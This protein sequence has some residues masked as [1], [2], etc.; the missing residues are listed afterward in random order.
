MER[1]PR[2]Q[3]TRARRYV[4]EEEQRQGYEEDVRPV[5]AVHGDQRV[6]ARV[7][8]QGR[9][10]EGQR[11]RGR[12]HGHIGHDTARLEAEHHPQRRDHPVAP[13]L[14]GPRHDDRFRGRA[15]H[16]PCMAARE[17]HQPRLQPF[18]QPHRRHQAGRRD[19][20]NGQQPEPK[21]VRG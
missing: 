13:G 14:C 20:R 3:G 19:Q 5:P 15:V 7:V 1:R 6:G 16:L 12:L 10:Q 21:P 9:T 18:G 11:G 8:A 17:Q 4:D 2:H